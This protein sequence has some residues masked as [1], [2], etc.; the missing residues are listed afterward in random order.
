MLADL[1]LLSWKN[2]NSEF[3]FILK[4][5]KCEQQKPFFVLIQKLDTKE[6]LPIQYPI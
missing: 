4:K 3:I 5:I 2:E 6:Y 1:E